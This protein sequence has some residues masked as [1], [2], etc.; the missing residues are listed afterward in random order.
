MVTFGVRSR[1][2]A[3][4][5]ALGPDLVC[6]EAGASI[7]DLT[8]SMTLSTEVFPKASCIDKHFFLH[9]VFGWNCGEVTM[10]NQ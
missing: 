6:V 2:E 9:V 3:S 4:G 7:L 1:I 8:P 5:L 10:V